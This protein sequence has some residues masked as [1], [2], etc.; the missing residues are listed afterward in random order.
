MTSI[1]HAF[2]WSRIDHCNSLLVLFLRSVYPLF[3]LL[4]KLLLN[5]LLSFLNTLIYHPSW[6]ANC[7]GF[8]S[9]KACIKFK[10]LALV[11]KSKLGLV[12]KYP[13]FLH[14]LIGL[15]NLWTSL[16]GLSHKLA[17]PF[18]YSFISS[19]CFS[20]PSRFLL[21]GT[22]DYSVDTESEFHAEAH[23]QLGVKDLPRVP[24]W[25]LEVDSNPQPTGCKAP[26]IPLHHRAPLLKLNPK[27]AITGTS[28]WHGLPF[29]LH[30]TFLSGSW[31]STF[32]L[33]SKW[34]TRVPKQS[35]GPQKISAK[36]NLKW[37]SF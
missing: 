36:P 14:H 11:L 24:T 22:P 2:V 4:S 13:L 16:T 23:E 32:T 25:R 3:N 7:A 10:V 1:V 35:T 33:F 5:W 31:S 8:L 30:E 29:T 21:R 15:S 28:W 9:L 19:T 18:I 34:W 26:N 6:S 17:P 27:V 20:A 12:Q 37:C